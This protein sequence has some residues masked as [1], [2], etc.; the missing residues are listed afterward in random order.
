MGFLGWSVYIGGMPSPARRVHYTYAEYVA[1]EDE[2]SVRH[3]Y[4]EGE[5]YAMAGG[6]P[7]HAARASV[8]VR[9]VLCPE[10]TEG[11]FPDPVLPCPA[12]PGSFSSPTASPRCR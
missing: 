2:S 12:P 7:D 8:T 4:L 6:T 11:P 1:L 3:E 9:G 5:I 10:L